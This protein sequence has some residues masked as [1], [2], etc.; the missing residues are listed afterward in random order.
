V[1][2]PDL[3]RRAR[4]A[5]QLIAVLAAGCGGR[6]ALRTDP[7]PLPPA[8]RIE[9]GGGIRLRGEARG[10]LPGMGPEVGIDAWLRA[11]G[12]LRAEL[13][14]TLPDG[15]PAHDVI[16]WTPDACLLV[17]LRRGGLTVLGDRPGDLDVEG[18]HLE[19]GDLVWLGLGRALPEAASEPWTWTEHEW[20]GHL[21][22][23]GLR[24]GARARAD[25]PAWTE[26][27][28]QD[29]TGVV[30]SLR[31]EIEAT[32]PSAWG[33]LPRR[34]HVDGDLLEARVFVQWDVESV[35]TIEDEVFDPL[36]RP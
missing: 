22:D 28:W 18:V 30:R 31:A 14:Y 24:A 13:Q 34:L 29:S 10:P 2:R 25:R 35:A 21:G 6:P 19:L 23:F 8:Y 27:A 9:D 15:R 32:A 20:R 36:W 5:L 7:Q 1:R 4:L 3:A 12:W 33:D 17:D 16:V 26:V 11:D